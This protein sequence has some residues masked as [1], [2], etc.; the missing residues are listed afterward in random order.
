MFTIMARNNAQCICKSNVIKFSY[1]FNI[2]IIYLFIIIQD[3]DELKKRT[4]QIID[5]QDLM[6]ESVPQTQPD[7]IYWQNFEQREEQPAGW[8]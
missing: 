4:F 6:K 8:A 2:I 3:A 5:F 7:P 1:L